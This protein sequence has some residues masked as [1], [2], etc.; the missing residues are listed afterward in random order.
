M[1]DN[2]ISEWL[3][4]PSVKF[5]D[6]ITENKITEI[7][8]SR[9]PDI[10]FACSGCGQ[11]TFWSW[12]SAPVRLRD[13]PVFERKSYL[14]LHKH[15]VDCPRCGVKVEK[16]DFAD[17]YSRCTTRFE[18]LV[19]R[20][21]KIT[22]LKQVAELLELDWKTVKDIDKKYLQ[23]EFAIPD[24]ENLRL[25]A[26]DE[27]SSHKG[28]NF[29]TI[30]MNLEKTKVIWVGKGR[31]KEVLDQFFKELG[32]ERAQK[33][34]AIAIDMWDP[35]IA[36]ITEHVPDAKTKIVFDKFH[37]INNYSKVIDKVRNME[38]AK[39]NAKDKEVIKGTK[40]L[41]LRNGDKLKKDQK[42]HLQDLLG[43]N[44]KISLVYILKD[45]L[46]RLWD[47]SYRK[48]AEDFLDSWIETAKASNIHP[49]IQFSNTLDRYRY[50]IINH[51]DYR[52]DTG[53]LEGMNNKIK[54][55]KRIAY[56]FH[57]DDYFILKI[58]QACSGHR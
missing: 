41:L 47:Y 51:C 29:F 32:P 48:C 7:K 5:A 25:V 13:L 12:D 28:Y 2:I 21:C 24:Y 17:Y 6:A 3:N 54:V 46:K 23:K 22:S 4:L 40:Y 43:L 49:L 52:I 10:G 56:G 37:I 55:V 42:Q 8:L 14:L 31:T 33:I 26:I 36:S 15:R 57:D 18:E 38:C 50:G 45:D 58:K 11:R 34:E 53:K 1:P 30:V 27:I 44:E 35:Y 16:L 39:A 20:L 9:F 19:A